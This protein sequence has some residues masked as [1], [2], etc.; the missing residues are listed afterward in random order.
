MMFLQVCARKHI[1]FW[2]H[3]WRWNPH[4]VLTTLADGLL[5]SEP[6]EAPSR[7]RARA[8]SSTEIEVHWEAIPPDSGSGKILAYEVR[9]GQEK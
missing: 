7:V 1:R 6:S 2:Q 9:Q 4:R 8:V 3:T 5:S